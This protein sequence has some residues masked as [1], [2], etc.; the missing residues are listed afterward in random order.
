MHNFYYQVSAFFKYLFL[1]RVSKDT[2]FI[3]AG[4]GLS[5]LFGI[6]I[7]I[8]LARFLG[9]VDWGLIAGV[10]SGAAI[11]SSL[12]DLGFSSGILRFVSKDYYQGKQSLAKVSLKTIFTARILTAFIAALLL[13]TS[14]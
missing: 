12:A 11:M 13:L 2:T 6:F 1:S 10:L 5:A 8:L 9:P 3:L 7:T 14:S 4:N